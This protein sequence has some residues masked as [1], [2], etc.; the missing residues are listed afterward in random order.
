M[1]HTALWQAKKKAPA[2]NTEGS[3]PWIVRKNVALHIKTEKHKTSRTAA[4]A[5]KKT[6]T[7]SASG[8]TGSGSNSAPTEPAAHSAPPPR[9]NGTNNHTRA[10]ERVAREHDS[11]ADLP[12]QGPDPEEPPIPETPS[13]SAFLDSGWID[14]S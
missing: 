12:S 4:R 7:S 5:Q 2:I 1:S 8:G 10:D 9:P 11:D 13:T 6:A 3:N 14:G